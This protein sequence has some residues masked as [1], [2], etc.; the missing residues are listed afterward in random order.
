MRLNAVKILGISIISSS[1]NEI[2]EEIQKY[3]SQPINNRQK[4]FK[5]FTPNTEQLVLAHKNSSFAGVLNRADVSLPDTVG[6]AWASRFLAKNHIEK[7]IPG[8]EFMEDLVEVAKNCHVPIGLIGGRANLAVDTLSCLRQKYGVLQGSWGQDGPEIDGDNVPDDIYFQRLARR[9]IREG[10]RV[11]FI[12]FGPPKQEYFIE[13]LSSQLHGVILMSVGGSFDII[14]GRLRRAPT[15]MRRLG[16]EWLWRLILEPWRLKRQLA[17]LE[18][19]WLVVREKL[20]QRA[21][22]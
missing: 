20:S 21:I 9:I 8:V 7:P 17:L 1:K 6:V 3:L 18:F 11:V 13:R 16:L 2:L 5:I 10:T 22:S 4:P 12:A 14:S 15:L 19:V